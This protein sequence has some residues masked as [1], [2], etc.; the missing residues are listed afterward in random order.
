MKLDF[1][2]D[3]RTVPLL[4][5]VAIRK[6]VVALVQ[7]GLQIPLLSAL[8][9]VTQPTINAWLVKV[10]S[11]GFGALEDKPRAGRPRI[12]SDE[13]LQWMLTTVRDKT[14]Q[15]M[16]FSFAYWTAV[17]VRQAIVDQFG[18]QAS[19]WTVR[20]ALKRM[21]L[22]PQKPK[23]RSHLRSIGDVQAWIEKTY[24]D[25]K[26][27]AR[28]EGAVIL[29]VD[30]AGMRADYHVG[31]TWGVRGKTPV[32]V[33]TGQ[34]FGWNM[35]AAITPDGQIHF[36]IQSKNSKAVSFIEFLQT[37]QA[38]QGQPIYVVADNCSIHTARAVKEFVAQS[39]GDEQVKLFFLPVYSPHLNPVELLWAWV[40]RRVGQQVF[41][42]QSELKDLLTEAIDQLRKAPQVVQKFFDQEDCKYIL[43]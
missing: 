37:I 13:I 26:A 22:T 43:A 31:R 42:T 21:G 20:R 28:S 9:S 38:E 16:K 39:K 32:V 18:V 15:Q 30:E 29:F 27:Q 2:Q 25:L 35:F 10:A 14:P 24:P 6:R 1:R 7:S 40:K 17:R 23:F 11:D 12:L 4:E 8:F 19:V 36:R 34:R 33:D 41:K 5:K 3:F